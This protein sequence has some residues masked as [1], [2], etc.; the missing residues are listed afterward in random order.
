MNK[1]NRRRTNRRRTNRHK[2]ITYF[3]GGTKQDATEIINEIIAINQVIMI[4]PH[5]E[6]A[7]VL[8]CRTLDDFRTIVGLIGEKLRARNVLF[9]VIN[10]TET[11][12]PYIWFFHGT[13]FEILQKSTTRILYT[14]SIEFNNSFNFDLAFNNYT[15]TA[16]TTKRNIILNIW[17]EIV[18]NFLLKYTNHENNLNHWYKQIYNTNTN[19]FKINP[20]DMILFFNITTEVF[21]HCHIFYKSISS[22]ILKDMLKTYN[23]NVVKGV[24]I[25]DEDGNDTIERQQFGKYSDIE[26]YLNAASLETSIG[27]DSRNL[28]CVINILIMIINRQ[29]LENGRVG[30]CSKSGGEVY[31]YFG[32]PIDYTN[33]IDTKIFY[34]SALSVADIATIQ[35]KI[36]QL[37]IIIIYYIKFNGNI[38]GLIDHINQN[39]YIQFGGLDITLNFENFGGDFCTRVRSKMISDI[40]LFSLDVYIGANFM[41]TTR[42]P[43]ATAN[44]KSY[45][46][47]SPLDV[48]NMRNI[49]SE[50]VIHEGYIMDVDGMV[51]LSRKYL[52][53]DLELLKTKEERQSKKEKDEARHTFLQTNTEISRPSVVHLNNCKD[54]PTVWWEAVQPMINN[55]EINTSIFEQ[56]TNFDK[57]L[58]NGT[59]ESY[60]TP[61]F[62]RDNTNLDLFE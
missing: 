30:L 3:K 23:P 59:D 33:D 19:V 36:L 46:V 21:R 42:T 43:T 54:T 8:I 49:S 32:F 16:R 17:G 34:S 52:L 26:S 2:R 48:A 9:N 53:E 15:E 28:R 39:F 12:S 38:E 41:L 13:I 22:N 25:T 47:T 37:L 45:M 56:L 6:Q 62:V 29:I 50:N 35:Q 60:K 58:I 4:N 24:N 5:E 14:I 44:I 10:S 20:N 61:L 7:S 55:T 1:T 57:T 40:R 31:R 11:N 51:I 27:R 18:F